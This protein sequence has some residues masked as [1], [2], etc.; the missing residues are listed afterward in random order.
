MNLALTSAFAKR[1]KPARLF[2]ARSTAM[3]S[4]RIPVAVAAWIVWIG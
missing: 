3:V 1:L 2:Q 4:A